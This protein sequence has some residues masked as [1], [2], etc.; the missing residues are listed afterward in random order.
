MHMLNV[1]SK[2]IK[3]SSR[4]VIM[5]G[6]HMKE[7]YETKNDELVYKAQNLT[8]YLPKPSLLRINVEGWDRIQTSYFRTKFYQCTLYLYTT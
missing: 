2:R 5:E 1:I 8:G 4:D 7:K 6:T 3:A